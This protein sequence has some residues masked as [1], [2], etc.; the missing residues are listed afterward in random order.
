MGTHSSLKS[1]TLELDLSTTGVSNVGHE[2]N[3]QIMPDMSE[4]EEVSTHLSPWV[5]LNVNF[6]WLI[7][8]GAELKPIFTIS[9]LNPTYNIFLSL[10]HGASNAV[11]IDF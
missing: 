8:S 9:G 1:G 6:P 11:R 5:M 2:E 7:F 4:E 10:Y 3:V